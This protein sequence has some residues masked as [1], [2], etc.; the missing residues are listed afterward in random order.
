MHRL[1]SWSM[2]EAFSSTDLRCT[3][4]ALYAHA[5]RGIQK[6]LIALQ[7][8]GGPAC[9]ETQ[10]SPMTQLRKAACPVT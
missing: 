10:A 2:A 9:H 5:C 4:F 1:I 7:L 3:P 6:P 8:W